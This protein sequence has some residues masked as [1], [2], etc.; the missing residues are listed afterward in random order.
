MRDCAC[1]PWD[2][3]AGRLTVIVLADPV[4]QVLSGTAGTEIRLSR[5]DAAIRALAPAAQVGICVSGRARELLAV[6][7]AAHR[8]CLLAHDEDMDDRGT[9]A[10]IAARALLAVAAEG[11]ETAVREHI[12]AY[13][14]SP[15]ALMHFL[16]AMSAAAEE[17]A[18]RRIG[19]QADLRWPSQP[20][21]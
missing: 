19:W 12:S 17:S 8:R 6:L 9:H 10:L 3:A 5:L 11:N 20:C 1:G 21:A 7:L 18:D 4:D 13:A 16:R 15:T 14:D 2:P